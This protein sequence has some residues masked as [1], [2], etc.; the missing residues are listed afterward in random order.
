[1]SFRELDAVG[2]TTLTPD[3]VVSI[4]YGEC[5]T[6]DIEVPE[7]NEY[8]ANTYISHNTVSQLVDSASGIHPRHSAYYLRTVRLDK[9]DPM[10]AFMS[11]AGVYSEDALGREDTTAVFYFPVKSP[12][13]AVLRDD[14]NALEHL[15]LWSIYH[16]YWCDHNPSIT[17]TV[18]DHE[19]FSVGAWVYENFD[20]ICGISFLPHSDHV[21]QQAPYIEVT[22][23][24]YDDWV[25]Q[26]PVPDVDWALLSGYEKEDN[27]V[28]S[29]TLA[30][31]G[32]V[33][34]L[35]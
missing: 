4:G 18:R 9:K 31:Q 12:E 21:Y 33:C 13:G 14:I 11:A 30:C 35:I 19:W 1:M 16:E 2:L 29:Q 22:K 7:G 8:L 23:E 20:K 10:C 24:Q 32:G 25:A 3:F 34:D 28:S 5:E 17:I 15:A 26:H 27:T 6:F